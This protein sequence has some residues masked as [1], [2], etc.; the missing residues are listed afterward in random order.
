MALIADFPSLQT[1]VAE[2]L[3]RVGDTAV[4]GRADAFIQLFEAKFKRKQRTKEM[5]E[6]DTATIVTA[7]TALPAGYLE[8]IRLQ[9]LSLKLPLVYVT[10]A[11]ASVLDANTKF[12]TSGT[13][14]NYT[15]LSGQIILAPQAFAPA[16]A[17]LEMAYYSFTPLSVTAPSNWLLAAHPDIYLY[18][19]LMQAAAYIDDKETVGLWNA[20]LAE[21]MDELT[22]ADNRSKVGAGPLVQRPTMGFRR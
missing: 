19:S 13:V 4:T 10:P 17:T 7:A 3:W 14:R 6:T 22:K 8:M 12:V 21:A 11:A 9:I 15:V 16:G 2:W 1:A 18:G 20:A 5:E